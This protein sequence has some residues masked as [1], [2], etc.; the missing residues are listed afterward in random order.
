[1]SRF[2]NRIGTTPDKFFIQFHF[3]EYTT[4]Q[5]FANPIQLKIL[6]RRNKKQLG[7]TSILTM[8]TKNL[9]IDKNLTIK[10][11]LYYSKKKGLYQEKV[12]FIEIFEVKPEGRRLGV[13]K[14]DLAK[15]A[16]YY[17]NS[18]IKTI[19]NFILFFN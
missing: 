17:T 10:S 19:F 4:T 7:D 6:L 13:I 5:F 12:I 16:N 15:Y 8:K 18:M 11:T 2:L 1:M 14:I 9:I 3:Q